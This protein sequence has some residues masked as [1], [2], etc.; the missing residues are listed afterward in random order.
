MYPLRV[1]SRR[2]GGRVGWMD[3]SGVGVKVRDANDASTVNGMGWMHK[4]SE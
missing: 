1:V 2:G 4:P 3:D